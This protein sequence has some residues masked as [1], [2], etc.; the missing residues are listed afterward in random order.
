METHSRLGGRGRGRQGLQDRGRVWDDDSH[1]ARWS[2]SNRHP[3]GSWG[4]MDRVGEES[5]QE[6]QQQGHICSYLSLCSCFIL[7]RVLTTQLSP[8]HVY[9]QVE[10]WMERQ[11]TVTRRIHRRT[12]RNA[13]FLPAGHPQTP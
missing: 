12:E 7:M 8:S 5:D 2:D 4:L 6:S 1:G 9:R 3:K 10:R 13:A 11:T